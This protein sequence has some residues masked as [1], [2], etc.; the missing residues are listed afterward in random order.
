MT[1][2]KRR[3]DDVRALCA[4]PH[5]EDG[6]NPKHL[7]NSEHQG[8][9]KPTRKDQQLCK[10]VYRALCA[11]LAGDCKDPILA[12]VQIVG[13]ETAPDAARLRAVVAIPPGTTEARARSIFAHLG[14]ARPYF[15][16]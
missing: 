14:R 2:R 6:I 4:A 15:R 12:D 10:Q 11:A 8:S 3:G 7:R 13:V 16:A 9:S 5:H 1:T